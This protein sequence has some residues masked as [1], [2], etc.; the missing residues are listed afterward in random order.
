MITSSKWL[1]TAAPHA[2]AFAKTHYEFLGEELSEY[3]VSKV[4]PPPTD[5]LFGKVF[6]SILSDNNLVIP[7]GFT[8]AKKKS[9][10]GR[11]VALWR[12]TLCA[13]DHAMLSVRETLVSIRNRIN[14]HQISQDEGLMEAY[15][16]GAGSTEYGSK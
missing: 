4:G 12:S 10:K 6:R 9:A 5:S 2:L 8:K 13:G 14:T 1:E 11:R 16:I 15:K 7:I 3:L